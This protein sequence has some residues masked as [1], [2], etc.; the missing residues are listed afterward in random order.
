MRPFD[1]LHG[2]GHAVLANADMLKLGHC[3]STLCQIYRAASDRKI[4]IGVDLDGAT[5]VRPPAIHKGVAR[6]DTLAN[7]LIQIAHFCPAGPI[8]GRPFEFVKGALDGLIGPDAPKHA[9]AATEAG[10]HIVDCKGN[11]LFQKGIEGIE[12]LKAV[13]A[14]AITRHPGAIIEDHTM[15]SIIVGLT[16]A[17]GDDADV[18]LSDMMTVAKDAINGSKAADIV[19]GCHPGINVHMNIVP[20]GVNKGDA[21]RKIMAIP[22]N[23]GMMPIVVGDSEPDGD[24]FRVAEEM[25]GFSIGVGPKAPPASLHVEDFTKAQ[26]IIANC[27]A[28]VVR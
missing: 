16:Q 24:M 3:V 2:N 12:H 21:L 6:E 27:A 20:A 17:T 25:G 22:G 1:M 15:C 18:I 28:L 7:S 26:K 5:L 8:T 14:K 9:F 13:F 19:S 4:L 23:A 10:A 11:I